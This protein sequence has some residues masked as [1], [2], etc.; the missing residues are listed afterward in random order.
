M[1]VRENIVNNNYEYAIFAGGCFWCMVSPFDILDGIIEVKSG[2]IGGHIENPTYA[3]V[4]SQK[5]GHYEA[6]KITY[7]PTKISYDKLLNVY[8]M[9]IDPMD[10]GGQFHDRGESYRTAIFYTSESQKQAAEKSKKLLDESGRFPKPIVTKILPATTFYLAEEYH[11]DFYKKQPVEYKKDR[12]ISGRDEFI[13][14]YWGDEY[15]S[16]FD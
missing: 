13:Q 9:Q 1:N 11:Q 6:I 3:D 7:D 5:S 16:I 12:G 2:Y 14:K 15:Y 10:D 8:W 4:K